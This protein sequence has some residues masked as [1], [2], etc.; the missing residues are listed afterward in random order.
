MNCVIWKESTKD[1]VRCRTT[2]LEGATFYFGKKRR[3]NVKLEDPNAIKPDFATQTLLVATTVAG[4]ANP[5]FIERT[6]IRAVEKDE[7][8]QIS[9]TVDT[10]PLQNRLRRR[11]VLIRES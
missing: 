4:Y 7:H 8:W 10:R 11:E 6:M 1:Q 3:P 9:T 5:A 2:S